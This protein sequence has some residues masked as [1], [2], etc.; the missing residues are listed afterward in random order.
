MN[1]VYVNIS[2]RWET[3][4]VKAGVRILHLTCNKNCRNYLAGIDLCQLKNITLSAW[5]IEAHTFL[6]GNRQ[7]KSTWSVW[8][9]INLVLC[10]FKYTMCDMW[11]VIYDTDIVLYRATLCPKWDDTSDT[12]TRILYNDDIYEMIY[13]F[14]WS[15]L[16]MMIARYCMNNMSLAYLVEIGFDWLMQRPIHDTLTYGREM[17]NW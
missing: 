11:N 10:R 4:G 12:N 7:M 1:E 16:S 9:C 2:S 17:T 15:Q 3:V 14:I 13:C 5:I 8:I 6:E